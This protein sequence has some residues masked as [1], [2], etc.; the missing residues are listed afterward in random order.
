MESTKREWTRA[1]RIRAGFAYW[2][3]VCACFVLAFGGWLLLRMEGARM[4][5]VRPVT[6]TIERVETV[7]NDDGHGHATTRRLVIYSYSIDSVRYTTDRVG[8]RGAAQQSAW[9]AHVA[10]QLR[11]GQTVTAYV[12]S[13]NPGSAFLVRDYDWRV[14]ALLGLPLALGVGLA[15]YWPW[16]GI[17][18]E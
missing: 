10:R 2:L 16:A 4:G 11:P 13:S 15:I 3:F 17:R 14:Y 7:T 8:S 18:A 6:A 5:D 12:A 9:A 1:D